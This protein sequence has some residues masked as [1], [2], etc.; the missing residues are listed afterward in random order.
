MESLTQLTLNTIGLEKEV[1]DRK[2]LPAWY[3]TPKREGG[4]KSPQSEGNFTR[5][6]ILR[7]KKIEKIDI[8][9][10]WGKVKNSG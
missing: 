8:R 10:K 3:H 9:R 2:N 6:E 5:T 4:D 7:H 1:K